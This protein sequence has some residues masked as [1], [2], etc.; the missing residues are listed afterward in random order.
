M[1]SAAKGACVSKKRKVDAFVP[2][3]F[4]SEGLVLKGC[5]YIMLDTVI[6]DLKTSIYSMHDVV[7]A[8]S[9]M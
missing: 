4:K 3:H 7:C 2:T 8:C 6:I 5:M 9:Y 1:T